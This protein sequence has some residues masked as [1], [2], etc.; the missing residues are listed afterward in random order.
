MARNLFSIFLLVGVVGIIGGNQLLDSRL[1]SWRIDYNVEKYQ[2][3][4]NI[5]NWHLWYYHT[6]NETLTR[7][8]NPYRNSRESLSQVCKNITNIKSFKGQW[9]TRTKGVCTMIKSTIAMAET[10]LTQSMLSIWSGS[11]GQTTQ[12]QEDADAIFDVVEEH[13][14]SI[15]QI[16]NQFPQ[17]V[18]F[19]L[20]NYSAN[21]KQALDSIIGAYDTSRKNITQVFRPASTAS[22]RTAS[23]ITTIINLMKSCV[24]SVNSTTSN[25]EKC[26]Q[27][28]VR[29]K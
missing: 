8:I 15:P 13:I 7:I 27:N 1:V 9:L 2:T 20:N 4:R 24:A 21:Y 6:V 5:D 19:M 18:S 11:I 29:K 16:Y 22:S 10:T 17:C 3:L 14:N 25:V 12:A 28:M 26:V 23:H